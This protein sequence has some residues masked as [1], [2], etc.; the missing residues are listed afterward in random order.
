MLDT[1]Q[2]WFSTNEL[3]MNSQTHSHT[4]GR[5]FG[6]S[7]PDPERDY[8]AVVTGP[9]MV[10]RSR[11]GLLEVTGKDRL[12]WLHNLTTNHVKTL[13]PG[14]GL[15][16][17]ALNV[18]GRILFDLNILALR[19]LL[20]LDIDRAFLPVA[21]SHLNKYII[22]EDVQIRDRSH[23]FTCFG[24]SGAATPTLLETLGAANART[25]AQF[26]PASIRVAEV[27]VALFR[28]DFCGPYGVDMLIPR[29]AAE[30]IWNTLT[31]SAPAAHAI[32]VG[33]EAVEIRRIEA[34]IPAPGSEITE[35]FLPA[36]T[37]QLERA[38]SFNKGCYLGQ[39]VV[40]RMRSRHVVARQLVGLR[41]DDALPPPG[42]TLL[43]EDEKPV[44]VVTSTCHSIALRRPI[45]LG[46]VRSALGAPGTNLRA[47]HGSAITPASVTG[48]P[49]VSR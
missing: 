32:P 31:D 46:Y 30:V 22:M 23:E 34:G 15:Y 35:E 3:P 47:V 20:R 39:E 12:A 5:F 40:E 29:E 9:A 1:K 44:G 11:R 17:F 14:D 24:L 10:H 19:N 41:F 8:A 42:T 48:L 38:V 4:D 6:P 49:F 25:L 16:A 13:A 26:G 28:H 18:K 33:M 45:G 37:G 43:A 7:R 27:D 36:E 21:M 2:K